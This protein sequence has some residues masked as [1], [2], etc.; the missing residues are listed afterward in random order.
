MHDLIS[1]LFWPSLAPLPEVVTSGRSPMYCS[2][3]GEILRGE[4]RQIFQTE[5]NEGQRRLEPQV[6]AQIRS[7]CCLLLRKIVFGKPPKPS[8]RG[9][10]DQSLIATN[11]HFRRLD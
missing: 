2:K 9:C 4:L 7:L 10:G 5:G 6:R 11:E 8:R 3:T 1:F